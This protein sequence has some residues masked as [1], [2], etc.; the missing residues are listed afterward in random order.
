MSVR[1]DDLELVAK[2]EEADKALIHEMRSISKITVGARRSLV[3]HR[4]ASANGSILK[5]TGRAAFRIALEGEIVGEI[6]KESVTSLR[7]KYESGEPLPFASDITTLVQI[8]KI[9]IER[10]HIY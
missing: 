1:L 5:D 8:Q 6:A 9:L 4:V 7:S 10:L 2:E 3:E